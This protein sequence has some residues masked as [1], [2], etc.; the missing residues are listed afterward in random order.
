MKSIGVFGLIFIASI[1]A[2]VNSNNLNDPSEKSGNKG[3]LDVLLSSGPKAAG[4]RVWKNML[5]NFPLQ[6]SPPL[7]SNNG[8]CLK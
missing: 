7:S 2:T 1:F 8:A 4:I 6:L 5:R 3:L